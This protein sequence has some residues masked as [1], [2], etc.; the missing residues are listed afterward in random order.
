MAAI[1]ALLAG[2]EAAAK[3]RT[4]SAT[5]QVPVLPDDSYKGL[6]DE[7]HSLT[8]WK[9]KVVLLNFWASWCAPCQIEIKEFIRYQD[10]YGGQGLQILGL[11]L[12]EARKLGNVK[13]TLGINYPVLVAD[14]RSNYSLLAEWGNPGGMI[15]YSVIF[16]KTGKLVGAHKGII[17]D[18]TFNLKFLPLLNKNP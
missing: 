5:M 14:P 17:D 15:P 1:T 16:D 12:D 4:D 2:T 6:D 9:G 8:E 10:L 3:D 13:R 11:G 18:S 7:L